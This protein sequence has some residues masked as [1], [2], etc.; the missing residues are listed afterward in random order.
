MH[1]DSPYNENCVEDGLAKGQHNE[2]TAF[3]LESADL[4]DAVPGRAR[5]EQHQGEHCGQINEEACH[6][7]EREVDCLCDT[8]SLDIYRPAEKLQNEAKAVNLEACLEREV[9]PHAHVDAAVLRQARRHITVCLNHVARQQEYVRRQLRKVERVCVVCVHWSTIR[10][11]CQAVALSRSYSALGTRLRFTVETL[12]R[13]S[14]FT[15]FLSV[16]GDSHLSV[17]TQALLRIMLLLS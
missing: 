6:D 1:G 9:E 15:F 4:R 3:R 11:R 10:V 17:A 2:P 13:Q 7:V 12:N 8:L 5:H 16:M 14:V